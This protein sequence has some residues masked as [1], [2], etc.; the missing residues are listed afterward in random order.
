MTKVMVIFGGADH[1]EAAARDLA[2]KFGCVLATATEAGKKVAAFNAYKADDFQVD[3]GDVAGVDQVIIFE[4]ARAAAGEMNVVA[5]CDH[6]NPGDLG[7]NLGAEMYWQASSLGQLYNFLAIPEEL[8]M[9]AAGDH[10]PAD[11][12]AGKCPGVNPEKFY[13]FRLAEKVKF[14]ASNPKMTPKSADEISATIEAAKEKLLEASAID[15]VRDLRSAGKIDE[16]PEAALLIGE[17]YMASLPDT[18]R[19]GNKTGNMKY[20]LGGHTTP[21]AVTKFMEWGNSLPN[22]VDKA[23]GNPIRGFAGVVVAPETAA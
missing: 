8:K 11:A 9:I 1:E 7:F 2:R 23:Y 21:E 18:D 10:C 12:Y 16:L 6:H 17:A 5:V 19:E 4:C 20:V 14:Y 22:K 15:G 13:T 3:E